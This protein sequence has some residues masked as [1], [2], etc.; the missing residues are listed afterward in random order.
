[1]LALSRAAPIRRVRE[2]LERG[3]A[4]QIA[5]LAVDMAGP[6]SLGDPR[7]AAAVSATNGRKLCAHTL[8]AIL[9][10]LVSRREAG[11]RLDVEAIKTSIVHWIDHGEMPQGHGDDDSQQLRLITAF[12]AE[13]A[14]QARHADAAGLRL[15]VIALAAPA[16]EGMVLASRMPED[17][18]DLMNA[19]PPE[20]DKGADPAGAQADA[21]R[22]N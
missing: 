2:E 5:E 6:M 7:K 13:Q 4:R 14:Q 3:S 9:L 10:P 19:K 16:L 20:A 11:Q 22:N 8:E 12:L 1:M 18:I 17:V 21:A 15:A